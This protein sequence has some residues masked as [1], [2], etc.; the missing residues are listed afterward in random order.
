MKSKVSAHN[1]SS[2]SDGIQIIFN[3]IT[4]Y[5]KNIKKKTRQL[6]QR[7]SIFALELEQFFIYAIN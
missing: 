3:L 6:L 2:L 4:F 1:R 7:H 5:W